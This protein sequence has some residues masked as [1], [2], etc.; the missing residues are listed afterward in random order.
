MERQFAG[1]QAQKNHACKRYGN[2]NPGLPG[3][4]RLEHHHYQRHKNGVEIDQSG[5]QPGRNE[6]VGFKQEQAA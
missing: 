6:P 3:G 4:V 1:R 2:C 5:G